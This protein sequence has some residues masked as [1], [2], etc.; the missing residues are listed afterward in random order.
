[1][2]GG[3]VRVRATEVGLWSNQGPGGGAEGAW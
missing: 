1:M 2:H 3:A